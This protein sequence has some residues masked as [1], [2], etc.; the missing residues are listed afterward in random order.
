MAFRAGSRELDL[1][2]K[3]GPRLGSLYLRGILM[4]VTNPKVSIFF[5]P[6]LP[7]FVDPEKGPV[8][9]GGSGC[10]CC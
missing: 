2:E 8:L 1:A 4:N 7:Q 3:G 10:R 6:F 5:L 9:G